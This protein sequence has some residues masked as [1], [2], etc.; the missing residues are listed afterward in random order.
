VCNCFCSTFNFWLQKLEAKQKNLGSA[1]HGTLELC[2]WGLHERLNTNFFAQPP[3]FG[4]ESWRLNKRICLELCWK[5]KFPSLELSK[6][7]KFLQISFVNAIFYSYLTL[8]AYFAEL[9]W[10]KESIH[11]GIFYF[12]FSHYVLKLCILL[13]PSFN[14]LLQVLPS[15]EG[16][17]LIEQRL[18]KENFEEVFSLFTTLHD[19]DVL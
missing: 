17:E 2:A 5:A 1:F 11:K 6:V 10:N 9:C 8:F 15:V 19:I 16:D 7:Q 12:F 3:T 14:S 13:S 18:V 4:I